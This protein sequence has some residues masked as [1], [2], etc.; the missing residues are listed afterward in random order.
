LERK[1]DWSTATVSDGQLTVSLT[2]SGRPDSVDFAIAESSEWYSVFNLLALR[3]LPEVSFAPDDPWGHIEA[4]DGAIVVSHI[5]RDVHPLRD[6]LEAAVRATHE[7][8]ERR[9]RQMEE[10][11]ARRREEAHRQEEADHELAQRFREFG[12]Q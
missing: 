3:P 8:V 7:E 2:E 10:L 5:P 9:H 12:E 6:Q 4:S 11:E 1:I